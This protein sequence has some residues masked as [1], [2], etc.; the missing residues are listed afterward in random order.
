MIIYQFCCRFYLSLLITLLL[1]KIYF[2]IFLSLYFLMRKFLFRW[3]TNFFILMFI[4]NFLIQS[5]S[6][7]LKTLFSNFDN[8]R[9]PPW[10]LI[11]IKIIFIRVFR[12]ISWFMLIVT[13]LHFLSFLI[14]LHIHPSVLPSLLQHLVKCY[15]VLTH[16]IGHYLL[17]RIYFLSGLLFLL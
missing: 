7:Y 4:I 6:S 3:I 15:F 17:P 2:L 9:F 14:I 1:Y 5:I 8:R 12:L 16:C 11:G 10:F 13:H